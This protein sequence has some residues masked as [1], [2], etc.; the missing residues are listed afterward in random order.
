MKSV[1]LPRPLRNPGPCR[2]MVL[3]ALLMPILLAIPT[4]AAPEPGETT[5]T[6]LKAALGEMQTRSSEARQRLESLQKYQSVADDLLQGHRP[7]DV[8]YLEKLKRENGKAETL[9]ASLL[10]DKSESSE[11]RE[12]LEAIRKTFRELE[13]ERDRLAKLEKDLNPGISPERLMKGRKRLLFEITEGHVVIVDEPYYKV[14]K[15][16]Y[17]KHNGRQ[18]PAQLIKRVKQGQTVGQALAPDGL[19]G[20]ALKAINDPGKSAYLLFYVAPDSIPQYHEL[21]KSIR[22]QKIPH[23]WDPVAKS[24]EKIMMTLSGKTK[25]WGK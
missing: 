11:Q 2:A 6:R 19:I 4:A 22:E 24:K 25:N 20:K 15:S 9:L 16:G 21:A 1:D 5:I 10:A 3:G 14:V 13:A 8:Q 17:T 23:G 12:D 18:V 7:I